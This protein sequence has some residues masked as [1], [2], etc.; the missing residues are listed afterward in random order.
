VLHAALAIASLLAL[1]NAS[2]SPVPPAP[3]SVEA[4][5]DSLER[6][7]HF[8]DASISADG[9]R[10][11]WSV[12]ASEGDGPERLGGAGQQQAEGVQNISTL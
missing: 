7:K 3:G 12:K 1:P 10:A 6:V 8:H 9:K 2:A 11:A 4:V 5:F